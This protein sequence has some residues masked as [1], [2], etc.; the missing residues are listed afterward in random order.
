MRD[1]EG[2]SGTKSNPDAEAR[3]ALV[4][5]IAHEIGNHLAGVRL[6]AH[7]LD[8]D[9][10]VAG[11]ARASLAID[12]LA[13][14]AGPLLA[15]LR[16]LLAPGSRRAAGPS[17]AALLDGVA[18]QLESEGVGGRAIELSI[19]SDATTVGPAFEGLQ[20]LLL[21]LVGA[22][23]D[24][25]PGKAPISLS[26]ALQGGEIE[27]ACALPGE[28]FGGVDSG[29]RAAAAPTGPAH[30]LRGRSLAVA[31]ARVLA[32]DAGGRV[33]LESRAGHSRAVL[34]LPRD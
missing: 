28:A 34:R 14:Q 20:P 15:L 29:G 1:T 6:E 7:M 32:A 12:S 24:L 4:F 11:L 5:A 9:L 21:A 23:E 25:P 31:I 2:K 13:G 18:R 22:P 17:Y 30:G 3:H 8:E 33:E 26:L 27:I 10:G 16:P 19:A